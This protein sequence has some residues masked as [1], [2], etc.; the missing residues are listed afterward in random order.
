M[1]KYNIKLNNS[2]TSTLSDEVVVPSE[3]QK[4]QELET[5]EGD[6]DSDDKLTVVV[7]DTGIDRRMVDNHPWFENSELTK[8]VDVATGQGKADEDDVGHGTGVASLISRL[9]PGV[10]LI[11]LRIFGSSGSGSGFAKIER[12]YNWMMNNKDKIDLVNM[13]WGASSN[14]PPLN[15]IHKRLVDSGIHDVVAAGNSGTDGGSPATAEG[16]FS[17][18]ALNEDGEPTDFSSFD[19]DQGNPDV[20]AVGRNVKVARATN[21]SMGVPLDSKFVKAS[22]TSF[23]A[24]ITA[25][26]Y[27]NALYQKK[28]NWDGEFILNAEDIP[29]TPKDGGG[30]LKYK[31]TIDEVLKRKDNPQANGSAWNFKG[32]DT[33]WIDADWLPEGDVSVELIEDGDGYIDLRVKKK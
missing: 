5:F 19:P 6:I 2:L 7:M 18:G 28:E 21:T 25:A 33:M 14:F 16:A 9:T 20:A 31:R 12:A 11:S 29:G 10:E 23:S 15:R 27:V 8:T 17:V 1:F 24:P 30:I 26:A 4:L 3:I 13:S 22:G 32:N